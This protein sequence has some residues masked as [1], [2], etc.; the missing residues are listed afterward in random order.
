MADSGTSLNMIPDEDFFKI[1]NHFFQGRFE[2]HKSP[3]TL[4]V[5]KCNK[6]QHESIPDLSLHIDGVLYKINRNQ[7][8]ERQNDM[9]VIKFM[10]AP[11][12]KVWILGLNFFTNYYSIFDYESKRIGFAESVLAGGPPSKSFMKWVI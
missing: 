8:F 2:C 6:M 3:T 12:R 1:Y 9:C 11:N 10:H 5:C 4:T 7:W